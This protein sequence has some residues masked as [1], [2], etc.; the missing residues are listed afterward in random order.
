M[1]LLSLACLL[2]LETSPTYSLP[3]ALYLEQETVRT[4]RLY[5]DSRS[6]VCI[7]TRPNSSPW[8]TLPTVRPGTPVNPKLHQDHLPHQDQGGGAQQQPCLHH[9]WT[10]LEKNWTQDSHHYVYICIGQ[11]TTKVCNGVPFWGK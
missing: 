5:Q 8:Q 4:C 6:S 9:Q 3:L 11:G 10:R 7:T 1:V 2:V